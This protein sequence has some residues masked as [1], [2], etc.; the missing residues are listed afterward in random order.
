MSDASA[1]TSGVGRAPVPVAMIVHEYYPDD[2]R[3]RREALS[4][5]ADGMDVDVVCLR[6]ETES[7]R[8]VADGVTIY[9]MPVRRHRG[10]N[11]L[12][13]LAEYAAFFACAALRMTTLQ[14]RRR[15]RVVQVHTPPDA[16]VFAA[17]FSRLAGARIVLD[18]H[19]LM[20]ELFRSKYGLSEDS[21]VVR[22]ILAAE[23]ASTR[24][25]DLVIT[26]SQPFAERLASRGAARERLA[27]IVNSAE[28]TIFDRDCVGRDGAGR[29]RDAS[30]FIVAWHGTIV[31]RYGLDL[32]VQAIALLKDRIPGLEL[33][34]YG[35]GDH[36]DDLRRL[37][38]ESHVEDSVVF[39]GFVAQ[40]LIPRRLDDADIGIV[41]NRPDC[42]IDMAFPTKV[43]EYVS[44]ELPVVATRTPI[45][46]SVFSDEAI[47]YC[48][49]DAAS[50]AD[51]IEWAYRNPE[52]ME[53]M[54][55]N[56][57]EA[58]R[59]LRWETVGP[60]YVALIRGLVGDAT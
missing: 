38:V 28:P 35:E 46:E 60:E 51:R 57:S 53:E 41:T 45:L 17:W 10:A 14:L 29:T 13:Y 59:P 2:Q 52:R 3:V 24:F 18:D 33:R 6:R 34:I 26:A 43:F 12:V 1:E 30:R 36:L 4:L 50:V 9:R 8:E 22:L 25:C 7:R 54:A 42:H 37:A 49:A 44:M 19:D 21:R 48:E 11:K 16:L 47:V 58:Y 5:V 39:E 27:V 31:K 23:R 40:E 32:A 56:A 20:G 15:Y 55:R